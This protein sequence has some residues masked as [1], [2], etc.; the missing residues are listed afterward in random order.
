[1]VMKKINIYLPVLIEMLDSITELNNLRL[2]CTFNNECIIEHFKSLKLNDEEIIVPR[3]T[4]ISIT[5][6]WVCSKKLENRRQLRHIYDEPPRRCYIMCNR[7]ECIMK[8]QYSRFIEMMDDRAFPL[9]KQILPSK[10]EIPRSNGSTTLADLTSNDLFIVKGFIC[11]Q[12]QWTQD[13][14]YCKKFVELNLLQDKLLYNQEKLPIPS[15]YPL[16]KL[17]EFYKVNND[18]L[19]RLQNYTQDLI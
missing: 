3:R 16:T 12:F 2:V 7:W 14:M 11:A 10:C 8:T 9:Y 13:N 19:F 4:Y 15:Y 6:C 18:Q 1:M 5:K 17:F